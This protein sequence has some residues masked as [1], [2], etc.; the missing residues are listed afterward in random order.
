[1]PKVLGHAI[2]IWALNS[3]LFDQ[4]S[5]WSGHNQMARPQ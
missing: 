4:L 1:M 2:S 5:G 3:A